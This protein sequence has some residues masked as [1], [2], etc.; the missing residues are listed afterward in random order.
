M[1][2]SSHLAERWISHILRAGIVLSSF[3]MIA[4]LLVTAVQPSSAEASSLMVTGIVL[5]MLT[6]FL[7]VIA[8]LIVFM[9]ERDWKFSAVA[10]FVLLMLIGEIVFAFL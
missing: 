3:C 4:G 1:T 7:R 8:T 10:L 2:V 9:V 5:L 6:P